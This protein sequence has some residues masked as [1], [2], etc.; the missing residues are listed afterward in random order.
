MVSHAQGQKH[1]VT[2]N[3]N[4]ML[5]AGEVFLVLKKDIKHRRQN[6]LV[7]GAFIVKEVFPVRVYKLTELEVIL[8]AETVFPVRDLISFRV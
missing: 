4:V 2:G 7:I 1:D 5:R 3:L 8:F 6:S